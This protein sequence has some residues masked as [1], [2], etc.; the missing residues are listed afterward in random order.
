MS[1][2]HC[3]PDQRADHERDLRKHEWRPGDAPSLDQRYT[4][5]ALVGECEAIA[6]SGHLSEPAEQSLRLLIAQTLVAFDMP[7]K[8]DR[9]AV[10]A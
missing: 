9:Q 1:P 3:S 2:A 6:S 8:I 7:A 10:L 5:A 4:V